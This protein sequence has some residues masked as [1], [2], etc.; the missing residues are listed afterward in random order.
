LLFGIEGIAAFQRPLASR[1]QDV[2]MV[3]AVTRSVLAAPVKPMPGTAGA[4]FGRDALRLAYG[5]VE[6]AR[7]TTRGMPKSSRRPHRKPQSR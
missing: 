2:R 3:A 7:G 5:D 4:M 6:A 1:D